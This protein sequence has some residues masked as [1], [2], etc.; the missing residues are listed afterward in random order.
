MNNSDPGEKI[1]GSNEHTVWMRAV[2]RIYIWAFLSLFDSCVVKNSQD[3]GEEVAGENTRAAGQ[4]HT[5][6][7]LHFDVKP[8]PQISTNERRPSTRSFIKLFH[9]C[10]V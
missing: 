2:F 10:T 4:T 7:L 6:A 1:K 5:Q 8:D 3:G 9:S